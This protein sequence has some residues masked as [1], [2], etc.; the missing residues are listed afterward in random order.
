M[1]IGGKS[2]KTI[3]RDFDPRIDDYMPRCGVCGK[4]RR[5]DLLKVH[6]FFN[7]VYCIECIQDVLWD[8]ARS[9]SEMTK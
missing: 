4:Y 9:Y 3:W 1:K 6:W 2:K 5:N 8:N 7:G